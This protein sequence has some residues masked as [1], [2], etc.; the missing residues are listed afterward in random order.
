MSRDEEDWSLVDAAT[1]EYI[2]YCEAELLALSTADTL[3]PPELLEPDMDDEPTV[4]VMRS[5][6]EALL[7]A[8]VERDDDAI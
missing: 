2:R 7:R 3:S 6:L 8:T 4:R 5:E 1:Q